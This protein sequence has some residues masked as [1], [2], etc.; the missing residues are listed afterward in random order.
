MGATSELLGP[1][2]ELELFIWASVNTDERLKSAT[3]RK[4]EAHAAA[5]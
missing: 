3:M 1:A 4:Y 2:A 5:V